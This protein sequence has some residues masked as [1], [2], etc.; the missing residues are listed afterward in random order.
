MKKPNT[1]KNASIKKL[2]NNFWKIQTTLT[3][4]FFWKIPYWY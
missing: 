3:N 1:K 2:E 4:C